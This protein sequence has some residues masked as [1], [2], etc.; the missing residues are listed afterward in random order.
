MYF[1]CPS[2]DPEVGRIPEVVQDKITGLL[3][4]FGDCERMVR[5]IE[6]L[7]KDRPLRSRLGR[8]AQA[9]AHDEFSARV[10]VSRY[11]ELYYRAGKVR[12]AL[13]LP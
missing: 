1:A 11:E 7:I 13:S 5:S 2:V 9:R 8:A 10:I 4:P 6:K 3:L 12:N